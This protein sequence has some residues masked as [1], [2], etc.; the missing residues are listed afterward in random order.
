MMPDTDMIFIAGPTASGKSH[1]GL[2]LAARLNGAI[3]NADSMQVYADIPIITAAPS[4]AE[5]ASAPHHLFAHIDPSKPYSQAE[6]LEDAR[7]AV[8]MIRANGQIPIL[9]GGTGFYFKA[10]LDG[11]VPMPDIPPDI[12][13]QTEAMMRALDNAELHA[14]LADVDPELANRLETGDTQRILRGLEIWL[15]SQIPLSQWQKGRPQGQI[16]GKPLTIYLRPPR[17]ALYER[18]NSRF[19]HMF[20]AGAIDEV[21]ALAARQIDERVPAMKAVGVRP[22]LDMLRHEIDK[23]T[24]TA[25]AMRDSRRYAKRQYTWFD[26]QYDADLTIN[27]CPDDKQSDQVINLILSNFQKEFDEKTC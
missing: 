12:K 6:W 5:M 21:A 19:R 8:A 7:Q 14:K 26:H 25:L 15:A 13:A 23:E 2:T 20:A 27:Q 11:I 17:D 18:I 4:K 16:D 22:I 3:I 9:V 10:A 24:A 1:L